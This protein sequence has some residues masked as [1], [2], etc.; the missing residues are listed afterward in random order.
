M[1]GQII[2][3]DFLGACFCPMTDPSADTEVVEVPESADLAAPVVPAPPEDCL[4]TQE[5]CYAERFDSSCH[6]PFT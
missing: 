5:F 2:K 1:F 4:E 6:G 3:L